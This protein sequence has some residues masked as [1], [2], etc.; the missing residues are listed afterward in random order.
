[1]V[2]TIQCK[3]KTNTFQVFIISILLFTHIQFA[4]SQLPMQGIDELHSS[5]R[6][7]GCTIE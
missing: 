1:M 2:I 7:K 6:L 4:K 3:L 5:L